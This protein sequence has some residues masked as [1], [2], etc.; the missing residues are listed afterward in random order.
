MMKRK[1]KIIATLGP[2]S[3]SPQMI[4]KL[5]IAGVNVFRLN[6]SHGA[7]ADHKKRIET[8]REVSEKIQIE[9]GI[10]LDL[11]GP[12]IRV[13]K[14]PTPLTLQVGDRCLVGF[15]DDIKKCD[16]LPIGQT[17]IPTVYENFFDDM[18]DGARVLFDDG[19]IV[20]KALLKDKKTRLV[21]IEMLTEGIL[22]SNKG[23]NLPDCQ[24]SAPSLTAKD[25]EDLLFGLKNAVD[26]VA[27]SFVRTAQDIYDLKT[28]L[29]RLKVQVPVV[30]KIEKPEAINQIKEIIEATD[31]IMIARGD[32]G[33][34]LGNH[35]VPSVQ[36]MIIQQCNEVGRPVITATQMLESMIEH[37]TPTRAE[38]SDV[39]N[40]IWDGT[41]VVML[42]GETASGKYPLE[43][44]VM[45]DK[46]IQEAEKR[47]KERPLIR[48][49]TLTSV[50]DTTVLAASMIAEKIAAQFI[51]SVTQ[52]GS[53]CRKMGRFRP[54]TPV[55]GVTYA[56]DVSRRLC[57][58]WGIIPYYFAGF[59]QERPSDEIEIDMIDEL[60]KKF[61][62][63]NGDKIVIT[64]G[65][66]KFFERGR[67]NSIR[68]EIVKSSKKKA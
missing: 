43:A 4:E 60:K 23:I 26:F 25:K 21:E 5:I 35:L 49:M 58:Y 39:A 12:K 11:Q 18:T 57:L 53:S 7:H 20:A 37:S 2:V 56:R 51:V 65:D 9:V 27:L 30:A 40:A 22:K 63:K 29:H 31:I 68:V 42:S 64:R 6:M 54:L 55:I 34:E 3:D 14:L 32:M 44:V 24:V 10:L 52:S 47:P 62:I 50:T 41:D 38:A 17:I 45:M 66:G 46:I 1:A 61:K 16:K 59:H 33:V 8:I 48:N 19:V 67:S 13:D 28:M 36:K 15:V